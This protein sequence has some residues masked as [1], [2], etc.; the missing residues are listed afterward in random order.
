[1]KEIQDQAGF[2][3]DIKSLHLENHLGNL[4]DKN[5]EFCKHFII[6]DLHYEGKPKMESWKM[7]IYDLNE[8]KL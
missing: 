4:P 2:I 1:M 6:P 3:S 5:C 7:I 8:I